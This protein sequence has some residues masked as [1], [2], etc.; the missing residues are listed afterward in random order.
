MGILTY[1]KNIGRA[2]RALYASLLGT[3]PASYAAPDREDALSM[4]R[5]QCLTSPY[6]PL[7]PT[8]W[9]D[10]RLMAGHHG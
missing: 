1:A 6:D 8:Q 10:L 2:A 3:A 9:Q 4:Y 7:M 5:L